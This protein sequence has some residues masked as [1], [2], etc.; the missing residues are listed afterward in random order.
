MRWV[1]WVIH[2]DTTHLPVAEADG[3]DWS[4]VLILVLVIPPRDLHI[5]KGDGVSHEVAGG[6]HE[7]V[8]G[9]Q[10]FWCETAFGSC[11][12]NVHIIHRYGYV[13]IYLANKLIGVHLDI[14]MPVCVLCMCR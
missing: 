13:C 3:G 10:L 2:I 4:P 1:G 6:F 7:V 9:R 8:I 14:Q 11:T 12:I 5:G